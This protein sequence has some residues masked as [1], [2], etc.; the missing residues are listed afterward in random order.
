[1]SILFVSNSLSAHPKNV[2]TLADFIEYRKDVC[3][4]TP[5]YLCASAI[6]KLI[7]KNNYLIS[8]LY[9]E[10]PPFLYED[11]IKDKITM[12]HRTKDNYRMTLWCMT[13][14]RAV[15]ERVRIFQ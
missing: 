4:E 14:I 5:Q 3:M 6:N 8:S 9:N 7:F 10:F 2:K 11:I 13:Y 12:V 15:N 1:M